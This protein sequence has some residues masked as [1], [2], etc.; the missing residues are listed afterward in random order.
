MSAFN[1][2]TTI[3]GPDSEEILSELYERFA[4]RELVLFHR[5]VCNNDLEKVTEALQNHPEYIESL[6]IPPEGFEEVKKCNDIDFNNMTGFRGL[7]T[8]TSKYP[9]VRQFVTG[10]DDEPNELYP[11]GALDE[12]EDN[13]DTAFWTPLLRACY[14]GEPEMVSL[15]I[16]N[17]ANKNYQSPCYA[18]A[19]SCCLQANTENENIVSNLLMVASPE[20][21][22]FQDYFFIVLSDEVQSVEI[23]QALLDISCPV[24]SDSEMFGEGWNEWVDPEV[25]ALLTPYLES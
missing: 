16:D 21:I 14:H 15:L 24:Y 23:V 9:A 8:Q 18:N 25:V 4:P 13:L 10:E 6:L 12:Q 7:G 17:G 20:N 11:T 5:A 3:E 22:L 2:Q 1:P 19:I